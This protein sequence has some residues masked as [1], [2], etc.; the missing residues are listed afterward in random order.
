MRRSGSLV[1]KE[2]ALKSRIWTLV[3]GALLGAALVL[4]GCA[5]SSKRAG[6]VQVPSAEEAARREKERPQ[7]EASPEPPPLNVVA[8]QGQCAPPADNLV[9]LGSCCNNTPCS[10]Q[11]VSG[12]EGKVECACFGTRGGCPQGQVCCRFRR[13]CVPPGECELP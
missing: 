1:V 7:I 13:R 11:C 5:E 2:A 9:T 6:A 4:A 12:A 8:S 3:A 10:G